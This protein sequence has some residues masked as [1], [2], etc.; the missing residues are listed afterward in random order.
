MHL[1]SFEL[2]GWPAPRGCVSAKGASRRRS[3]R[4]MPLGRAT[5][6]NRCS[7]E[8][9]PHCRPTSSYDIQVKVMSI[10]SCQVTPSS[11]RSH[12]AVMLPLSGLTLSVYRTAP[13]AS[14]V[15]VALQR[16]CRRDREGPHTRAR[17][18]WHAGS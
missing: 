5:W 1:T 8:A 17:Q 12:L 18:P 9:R 14:A 6:V 11:E 4:L 15:V 3:R 2:L 16:R 13:L 7:P 10:Q